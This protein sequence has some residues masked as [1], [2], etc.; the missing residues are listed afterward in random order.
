MWH[1]PLL[2][3]W[4]M[5]VFIFFRSHFRYSSYVAFFDG[6][7]L[8]LWQ[9]FGKFESHELIYRDTFC[10]RFRNLRSLFARLSAICTIQLRHSTVRLCKPGQG[11]LRRLFL[12]SL[13]SA[14]CLLNL[15]FL[16]R[17][18]YAPFLFSSWLGLVCRS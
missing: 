18:Y 14:F 3:D 4:R 8:A 1:F 16:P 10:D 15:F 11:I 13:P 7:I 9:N 6:A 17:E 12:R 5:W 2:S